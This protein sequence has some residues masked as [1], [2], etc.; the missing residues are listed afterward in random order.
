MANIPVYSTYQIMKRFSALFFSVFALSCGIA[1]QPVVSEP[2]NPGP[3]T[4]SSASPSTS[5]EQDC[6]IIEPEFIKMSRFIEV[7]READPEADPNTLG[8]I[9]DRLARWVEMPEPKF[10][11]AE[12]QRSVKAFREG[13]KR[14]E[15]QVREM[16]QAVAHKKI[17]AAL[18]LQTKLNTSLK[19]EEAVLS[20]ILPRCKVDPYAPY[21]NRGK[22]S[23]RAVQ[24]TIQQ[25][26]DKIQ[27][28]YLERL[29]KDPKLR[30]QMTVHMIVDPSGKVSYAGDADRPEPN[31]PPVLALPS[32]GK[33][34]FVVSGPP[35]PSDEV[36]TC[37][38]SAFKE[39]TFPSPGAGNALVIYPMNFEPLNAK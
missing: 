35:L 38:V 26:F 17:D 36:R 7:M 11:D 23:Y 3:N 16:Q 1:T 14:S 13:F 9:A 22:L 32:L 5:L 6:K 19:Q 39:L 27:S 28:C 18:S 34:P 25:S 21:R 8:M 33:Q 24:E 2:Q 12:M 30:G 31:S 29:K 15:P 20:A 37:V 10:F 4:Q